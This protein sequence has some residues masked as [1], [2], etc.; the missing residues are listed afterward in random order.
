MVEIMEAFCFFPHL[1]DWIMAMVR[2]PIFSLL[3]IGTLAKPFYPSWGIR[4]GD[5]ITP[6]LF[7]ILMEGLNRILKTTQ[8]QRIIRG[9]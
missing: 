4:Q 9:E 8:A 2:S 7:L 3:I 1:I 5:P 6:F